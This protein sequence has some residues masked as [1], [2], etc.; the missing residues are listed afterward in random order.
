MHPPPPHHHHHQSCRTCSR[1][2]PPPVAPR[3][4]ERVPQAVAGRAE[5]AVGVGGG[6]A[7]G[8]PYAQSEPSPTAVQVDDEDSLEPPAKKARLT[9]FPCPCL[10]LGPR[11]GRLRVSQD[12][13]YPP[14]PPLRGLRPTVGCQRYEPKEPTGAE[15]GYVA[16]LG[17]GRGAGH[18]SWW[19]IARRSAVGWGW[20]RCFG[21]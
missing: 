18:G 4:S 14:P 15:G 16:T 6:S 13:N 7:Q 19:A 17:L 5:G 21:A 12:A 10:A 11:G 3:S 2:R 1:R 8:R 9:V 20:R